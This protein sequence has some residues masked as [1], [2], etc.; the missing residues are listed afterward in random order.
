MWRCYLDC[1]S[2]FLGKKNIS[3]FFFTVFPLALY[4]HLKIHHFLKYFTSDHTLALNSNMP[5]S[6]FGCYRGGK[7]V[8]QEKNSLTKDKNK[9]T[10]RTYDAKCGIGI[11]TTPVKSKLSYH[12]L[13][14]LLYLRAML[15]WSSSYHPPLPHTIL[16]FWLPSRNTGHQKVVKNVQKFQKAFSGGK[17][18]ILEH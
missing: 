7:L 3:T 15:L 17:K 13:P 14:P 9:H 16:T 18:C 6:N 10:Q 8:K 2:Y 11:Q 5:Y 1:G 4:V 12:R